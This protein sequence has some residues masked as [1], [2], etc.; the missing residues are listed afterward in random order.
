[1]SYYIELCNNQVK[2][3]N[4]QLRHDGSI[5]VDAAR[6]IF[7]VF[8]AD[9]MENVSHEIKDMGGKTDKTQLIVNNNAVLY[10]ELRVPKLDRK[11]TAKVVGNEMLSVQ[12]SRQSQ[13]STWIGL[14]DF[15]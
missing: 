10:K 7:T 5:V 13:V 1:M 12:N 3:V 9:A 6:T 11:Q 8:D 4:A 15:E 2:I 14:H